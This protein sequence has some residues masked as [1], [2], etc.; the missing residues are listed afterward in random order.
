M[1]D[2]AECFFKIIGIW[3]KQKKKRQGLAERPGSALHAPGRVFTDVNL[4]FEAEVN[5]SPNAEPSLGAI[6]C[7]MEGH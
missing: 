5:I 3:I 2:W 4:T 6:C 7:G 1:K